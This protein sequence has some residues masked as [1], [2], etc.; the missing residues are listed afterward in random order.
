M[1]VSTFSI[2][3]GNSIL[4]LVKGEAG[5]G[6]KLYSYECLARKQLVA[7]SDRPAGVFYGDNADLHI[8]RQG[9]DE[10]S[11][12]CGFINARKTF[13][14][15]QG[16]TWSITLKIGAYEDFGFTAEFKWKLLEGAAGGVFFIHPLDVMMDDLDTYTLMPGM[17][18]DGNAFSDR[19]KDIPRLY[20]GKENALNVPAASLST[21]VFGFYD[22]SSGKALFYASTQGT[23]LGNSGF[24]YR[25]Y[26]GDC[27]PEVAIIAPC[28]RNSRYRHCRFEEYEAKGR[29]D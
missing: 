16:N 22:R 28:Y 18:Y 17:L 2:T 15:I 27:R 19:I 6:L 10:V 29:R 21:P 24:S 5:Y 4:E 12:E 20:P 23:D 7:C 14:D 3:N 1:I 25:K 9:F 13:S 8:C 26:L 11:R